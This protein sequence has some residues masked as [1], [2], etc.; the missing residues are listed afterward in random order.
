LKLP[1][2]AAA[3]RDRPAASGKRRS[4]RLRKKLRV[5]EFREL[6]FELA[7]HFHANLAASADN[8]FWNAFIVECIEARGLAYGG[9]ATGYATR[10]GRGSVSEEDREAVR[11]WLAQRPEVSSFELGALEDA[12][13]P[14]G[15]LPKN[16]K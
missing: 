10:A 7:M 6:G 14:G 3:E 15:G 1:E 12:R 5:G 4:R 13:Y 8:A 11:A 2:P 9:A 16:D